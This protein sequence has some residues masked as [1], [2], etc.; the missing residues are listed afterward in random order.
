MEILGGP[1]YGAAGAGEY[2][3]QRLLQLFLDALQVSIFLD[4]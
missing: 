2:T 3:G 1:L 4:Q